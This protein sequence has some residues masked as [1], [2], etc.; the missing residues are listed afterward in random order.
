MSAKQIWR[1][2]I[3]LPVLTFVAEGLCL[4]PTPRFLGIVAWAAVFASVYTVIFVFL[5]PP[6]AVYYA[7]VGLVRYKKPGETLRAFS[8]S[9]G[10]LCL[11]GWLLFAIGSGAYVR[12]LAFVR[13]SHVGDRIVEA[14]ALYK[15]KT[16]AY[17]ADL[18]ALVPDYLHEIPYTGMI[19]Y[20]EFEYAKDRNDLKIKP[21]Q[22]EL[23]IACS[24]GGINFDRFIYWPGEKYPNRIQGKPVERIR[25]WAYV[26]E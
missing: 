22:Y 16:G 9:I 26:H 13:A 11:A 21:N 18:R 24:S 8:I 3:F 15:Q 2:A 17:P 6:A 5:G 20:P 1:W 19:G 7:V 12:H 23:R 14:L 25:G 10:W 4:L